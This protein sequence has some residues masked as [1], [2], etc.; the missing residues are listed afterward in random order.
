MYVCMYME[1]VDYAQLSSN[2]FTVKNVASAT[3]KNIFQYSMETMYIISIYIV[4]HF[5]KVFY[6][7]TYIQYNDNKAT[8]MYSWL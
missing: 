7:Y 5:N 4:V 1:Q 6:Y 2:I 8:L 3:Y